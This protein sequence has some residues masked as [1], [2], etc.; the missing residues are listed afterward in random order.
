MTKWLC[1]MYPRLFLLKKIL[2]DD[3][4]IMI[5]MDDFEIHTLRL[6]MNEIF[7]INNKVVVTYDIFS[8]Q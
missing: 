7:G 6:L 2:K 3:G 4:V 1:M 8:N 5:S